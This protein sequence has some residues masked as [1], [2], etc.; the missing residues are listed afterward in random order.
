MDDKKEVF[1]LL[2]SGYRLRIAHDGSGASLVD[3]IALQ[4]GRKPRPSH[5]IG[6]AQAQRLIESGFITKLTEHGEG[7]RMGWR[8]A[9]YDGDKADWWVCTQ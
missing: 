4:Y 1:A 8:A 3:G 6:P 7:S 2:G 9:G 5:D